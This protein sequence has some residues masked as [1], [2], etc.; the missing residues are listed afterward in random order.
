MYQFHDPRIDSDHD[1]IIKRFESLIL[2]VSRQAYE[3][4]AR[5]EIIRML[6]RYTSSHFRLEESSMRRHRYPGLRDHVL[7]H[8]YMQNEFGRIRQGMVEG[9]PNLLSDIHLFRSMFLSHI[10]TYDESYAEWL[11]WRKAQESHPRGRPDPGLSRPPQRRCQGDQA[12]PGR[13]AHRGHPT[14]RGGPFG[15]CHQQR[16]RFADPWGPPAE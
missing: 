3:P 4:E 1:L 9:R 14:C 12:G 16:S 5:R 13:R 8:A 11:S 6:L 15:H 10:L 7:A 2:I